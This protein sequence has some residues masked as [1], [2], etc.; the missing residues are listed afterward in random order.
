MKTHPTVSSTLP[1]TSFP[2]ELPN[3]LHSKDDTHANLN[4]HQINSLDD[5]LKN[6]SINVLNRLDKLINALFKL[7]FEHLT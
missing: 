1:T 2:L 3:P 5:V 4:D 7:L 6:A